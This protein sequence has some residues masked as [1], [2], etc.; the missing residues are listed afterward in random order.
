MVCRVQPLE[1]ADL[2]I[3]LFFFVN[4]LTRLPVS[5]CVEL[6]VNVS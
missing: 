6:L 2:K 4:L 5:D 3:A 1:S